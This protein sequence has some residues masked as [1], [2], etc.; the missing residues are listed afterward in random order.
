LY[1]PVL[2][3]ASQEAIAVDLQPRFAAR[4]DYG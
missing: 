2:S 4:A 1:R 3:E